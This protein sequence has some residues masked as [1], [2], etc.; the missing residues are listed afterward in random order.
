MA[1]KGKDLDKRTL[2][3]LAP[4]STKQVEKL[5]TRL[6]IT[7]RK[8]YPLISG[9]PSALRQL[10]VSHCTLKKIDQRILKLEQLTILDLSFNHLQT[11]PEEWDSVP[12]LKELYLTDNLLVGLSR[13]FLNSHLK[14]SLALLDLSNNKLN[15][16]HPDLCC[17]SNLVNLKLD[18]NSISI[19]PRTIRKMHRLQFFTICKNKLTKVPLDFCQLRLEKLDMFDNLFPT[20]APSFIEIKLGLP[21]T[22]QEIAARAIKNKR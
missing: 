8:D 19:I 21:P 4:A 9:F 22:L 2:S 12:S 10:K 18:N 17:F 3:T 15:H 5:R 6:T 14:N 16:M 11:L 1:Y 13:G 20:T 7:S